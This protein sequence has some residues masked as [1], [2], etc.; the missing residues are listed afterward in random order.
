MTNKQFN[1]GIAAVT[2]IALLCAF[3]LTGF[4]DSYQAAREEEDAT[5]VLIGTWLDDSNPD[6]MKLTFTKDGNFQIAGADAATYTTDA[7]A[8]TVT[9]VY[10]SSFGGTTVVYTYT[11]AENNTKLTLTDTTTST[12]ASY[13]KQADTTE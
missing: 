8:G 6:Y 5:S 12:T 2:L 3:L 4:S 11:L 7:A 13:T 10:N 9:L 1:I